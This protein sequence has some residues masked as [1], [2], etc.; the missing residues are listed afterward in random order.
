M[1]IELRVIGVPK[2]GGSKKGFV[3]PKS[4]RVIIVDDCKQNKN[5]RS[6][7]KKACESYTGPPLDGPIRLTVEFLMPRPKSHY[8]TGKRAGELKPTAPVWHTTA[9][10]A[11]KL[12]RSTEDAITDSGLW[13][14][15]S[16][17][18]IQ[19]VYKRYAVGDERPGANITI[20]SEEVQSVA[21]A[22]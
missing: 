2:P 13:A 14:D 17:V 11:T 12:L 20:T 18:C 3:N 9:P 21:P 7:V 10:D 22:E 8:G 16:R 1:K 4:G 5:W 6:D 15:D 19:K